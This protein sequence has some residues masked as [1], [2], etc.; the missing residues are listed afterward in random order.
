MTDDGVWFVP[1][2]TSAAVDG[3]DGKD[4][5]AGVDERDVPG[6]LIELRVDAGMGIGMGVGA[7]LDAGPPDTDAAPV[8]PDDDVCV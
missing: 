6:D 3:R 1:F 4:D 2:R 5:T 8:E 7:V